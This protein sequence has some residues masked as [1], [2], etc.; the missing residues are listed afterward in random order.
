MR[1]ERRL[2]HV[3]VDEAG[4]EGAF[5]GEFFGLKIEVAEGEGDGWLLVFVK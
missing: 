4:V 3:K 5:S 1:R 2:V